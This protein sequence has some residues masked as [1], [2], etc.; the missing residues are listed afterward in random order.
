MTAHAPSSPHHAHQN[1][2][3]A[4]E[5]DDFARS[6]DTTDVQ[7]A[8]WAT[9]RD[10]GLDA[11]DEARFQ[12][13]LAADP[14]HA[15]AYADLAPGLERV[16]RLPAGTVQALKQGLAADQAR[17]RPRP[18]PASPGRRSWM[19][20]MLPRTALAASVAALAGSGWL[21]W[22]H[23][24]SQPTFARQYA[25]GRGQRLN[26]E[27]PDG[28]TLQLDT[29][30]RIEVLLYRHRR[31]V[32]LLDGQ[33]MFAVRH[34]AVSPFEVLAGATRI[35]VVGTRFSVRHTQAGMEAGKTVV[36]VESGRVR[37]AEALPAGQGRPAV[38][39]VAGQ[40]VSADGQGRLGATVALQPEGVGAWRKGRVSFND[41]PLA[42][43]LA[44][45]ERYGATGLFVRDPAVG[46][47]RLGGSFELHQV[48]AF[49]QALPHLLPVRL[50]RRGALTEIVAAR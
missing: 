38:E 6:Q 49:A 30:T 13:W 14:A 23:W 48:G 29:A 34:D 15:T 47:L 17:A 19:L 8:L 12:Q 16:R 24:Q 31:E 27:L 39:L 11:G 37:V 41:T 44:E 18:A 22:Q 20:G 36:A 50:V 40:G 2:A 21:G 46:A 7:A 32:R 33:A 43:A 28:S 9:R 5:F 25:A 35:T 42:D 1:A 45:F 4:R 3:D 10:A 26:V